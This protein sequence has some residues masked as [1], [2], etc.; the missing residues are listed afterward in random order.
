MKSFRAATRKN[1]G[2][3]YFLKKRSFLILL[4][5]AGFYFSG[6]AA[7]QQIK[8]SGD[9]A[10]LQK[11]TS[12]A[13]LPVA[14]TGSGQKDA[15]HMFRKSLYAN[16]KQS[17]FQILE[18]YVVDELLMRKGMTDPSEY[19]KISPID[20]GE[21][22]GADAVIIPCITKVKRLYLLLH[23]SIELSIT[24]IM[25]DTR[26]GELLWQ[27]DQTLYDFNGLGKIPTGMV[28]AV[29]APITFVTNKN[30]LFKMTEKM[31]AEITQL[32]KRPQLADQRQTFKEPVLAS[33]AVLHLNELR[34][35]Q[36][37]WRV[38][39]AVPVSFPQP[40]SNLEKP[41]DAGSTVDTRKVSINNIKSEGNNR[42]MYVRPK[43]VH[44]VT[45]VKPLDSQITPAIYSYPRT[46]KPI[47]TVKV[48]P[49][50]FK[51]ERKKIPVVKL[52]PRKKSGDVSYTVQ[53]GAFRTRKFADDLVRTLSEKGYKTFIALMHKSK[54]LIYKVQVEKFDNRAEAVEYAK[55]LKSEENLKNFVTTV[56]RS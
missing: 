36:K 20:F 52:A 18:R 43:T 46:P 31:A 17:K 47:S 34:T 48:K 27:A 37:Q 40:A 55:A 41:A 12:I 16:L 38:P 29:L 28:S 42:M 53:V 24:A 51:I 44:A 14:T 15:A 22:L 25:V 30:N 49:A 39:V 6:C 56:K 33:A 50:A 10:L 13:I 19:K 26:T 45:P 8:V 5:V 9:L 54:G 35:K 4:L 3:P 32:L 23:S 11:N 21:A 7:T 1:K 2:L